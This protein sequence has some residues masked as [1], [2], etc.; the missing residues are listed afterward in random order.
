MQL[1]RMAYPRRQGLMEGGDATLVVFPD[2]HMILN[3]SISITWTGLPQI[4]PLSSSWV[5]SCVE[6]G[7]EP[8]RNPVW[9]VSKPR[10]IQRQHLVLPY[11]RITNTLAYYFEYYYGYDHDYDDDD[12]DDDGDGY[13]KF[14]GIFVFIMNMKFMITMMMI[15]VMVIIMITIM[16][17]Y[18]DYY[19]LL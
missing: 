7:G 6:G 12:D 3:T 1:Q 18:N 8:R 4:S 15:I 5:D 11:M 14:N 17:I 9:L 2:R 19:P 13:N 16:M 10:P